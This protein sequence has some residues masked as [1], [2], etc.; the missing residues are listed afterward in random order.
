M[1][2]ISERLASRAQTKNYKSLVETFNGPSSY[3]TGGNVFNS[4]IFRQLERAT[5]L[6][7]MLGLT[8]EVLT[9]SVSGNAFTLRVYTGTQASGVQQMPSGTNLSMIAFSVL[10]EGF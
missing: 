10:L 9:G 3:A 7:G 8:A 2:R 5:A 4:T 1:S 6:P